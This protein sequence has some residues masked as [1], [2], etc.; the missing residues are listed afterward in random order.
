MANGFYV[1]GM[2]NFGQGATAWK[3]TGGAAIRTTLVD[4]ADYT[5]NLTTHVTMTDVAVAAR[6]ETSGDMTLVDAADDG[7]VDASD[8]TFTGT[9]GDQCEAVLVYQFITNDA[10]STPLFWWDSA[11]GLPVTLGGDVTVVWDNGSS[12]IAK[13]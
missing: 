2:R 5:V 9:A 6:E 10:G 12:K 11:T 13:I 4:T 3:A 7:I 1:R 8:V